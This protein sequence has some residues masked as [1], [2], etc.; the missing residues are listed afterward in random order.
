[1]SP[2]PDVLIADHLNQKGPEGEPWWLQ[3]N[4]T[5]F[6]AGVCA[7]NSCRLDTGTE[8]I[9]WAFVPTVDI[10][11]DAGGEKPF[12]LPFGTLNAYGSSKGVVR[13]HCSVCGASVFFTSDQRENLVD[14][15]IGLMAATEGARAESWLHWATERLSFREDAVPRAESLALAIEGGLKQ[16][17]DR[18]KG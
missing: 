7:C 9:Q 18:K 2:W 13:Y 15:A 1:M 8:T 10:H 12:E 3:A 11:L 16:Y 5:R 4:G 17:T 14:V 6:L